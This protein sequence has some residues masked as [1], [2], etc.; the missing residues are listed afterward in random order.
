M[1]LPTCIVDMLRKQGIRQ[2]TPIQ[3]QGLPTVLSARD[4]IGVAFTGSGKT[5][6]FAL[7]M[8]LF[9]LE[10]EIKMP[11]VEGEGPFGLVVC[12]SRELARQIHEVVSQY[13]D[14]LASNGFPRLRAMLAIG[15]ISHAEM[16]ERARGY[17]ARGSRMGRAAARP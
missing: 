17:D 4:M 3:V 16:L 9:A 2:P 6:V 15:G 12:P 1:K 10:E 7:P 8:V 5:L 13:C 11:F 14:T